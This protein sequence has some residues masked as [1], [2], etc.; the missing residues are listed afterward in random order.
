MRA[1]LWFAF[2]MFLL[3]GLVFLAYLATS[4]YPRKSERSSSYDALVVL[5]DAVIAF[6]FFWVLKR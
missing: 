5:L 4:E 3:E 1:A 2:A 6:W